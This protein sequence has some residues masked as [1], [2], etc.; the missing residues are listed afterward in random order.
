MNNTKDPN[1][2]S[3]TSL[4]RPN[5]KSVACLA[6]LISIAGATVATAAPESGSDPADLPAENLAEIRQRFW[7]NLVDPDGT[8]DPLAARDSA[9]RRLL[10]KYREMGMEFDE[11]PSRSLAV[12]WAAEGRPSEIVVP[13]AIMEAMHL[14]PGAHLFLVSIH[15]GKNPWVFPGDPDVAN[16]FEVCEADG[17]PVAA[18]ENARTMILQSDDYSEIIQGVDRTFDLVEEP[19]AFILQGIGVFR[20]SSA[21]PPDSQIWAGFLKENLEPDQVREYLAYCASELVDQ[22]RWDDAS[23]ILDQAGH[24]T[25]L[26]TV[27]AL[28]HAELVLT[29]LFDPA[30]G[31][32]RDDAIETCARILRDEPEHSMQAAEILAQHRIQRGLPPETDHLL[33]AYLSVPGNADRPPLSYYAMEIMGGGDLGYQ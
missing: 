13:L 25:P 33:K 31:K 30:S 5:F 26:P 20:I 4:M 32:S 9:Y 17:N 23:L 6:L 28:S 19:E 7:S 8:D 2:H 18:I 21:E 10:A 11:V 15:R 22:W 14:H 27:L 3:I 1:P 29:S 24:E 16:Y 12:R